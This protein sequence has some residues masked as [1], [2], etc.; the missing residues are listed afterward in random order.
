MITIGFSN[1]AD[2]HHTLET[3]WNNFACC[4]ETS[5]KNA[6]SESDDDGDGDGDDGDDEDKNLRQIAEVSVKVRN[7][8]TSKRDVGG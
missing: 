1:T 5:S 4:V 8:E 7:G 6:K 2:I 3:C